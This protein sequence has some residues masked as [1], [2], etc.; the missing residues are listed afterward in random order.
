MSRQ[1][2]G[3]LVRAVRRRRGLTQRRLAA[4]VGVGQ[5]TISLVERGHCGTISLDTLERI[6]RSLDIRIEVVGRWRGGDADR[7]LGRRHSELAE[8]VASAI[9]ACSGW[10]V[11]PEVSFSVFGERGVVDQLAWHAAARHL[12]VIELKTEFVDFNELLGTLDRKIRLARTIAQ[13]RGLDPALV[14][15][16][17]IVSDSSANR[18]QAKRHATLLRARLEHDG[19]S[20]AAMLRHPA[21]GPTSGLAFWSLSNGG[22]QRP[23]PVPSAARSGPR[24]GDDPVECLGPGC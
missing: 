23:D 14:S 15:V 9:C 21:A 22:A 6:G 11:L 17:L 5:T 20:L 13:E 18:R 16:W 8:S 7:L 3:S 24:E 1:Q 12:I 10:T 2:V 19:R 4:S